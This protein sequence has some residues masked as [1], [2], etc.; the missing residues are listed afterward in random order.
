MVGVDRGGNRD[1][2]AA[3]G[4]DVVVASLDE[5]DIQALDARLHDKRE[6]LVA[7]QIEQEGFDPTREHAVESIFTVGNGYLG[8][9]HRT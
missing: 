4:A 9:E 1:A 5:L 7:W 8:V 6:L 3:R 2:L